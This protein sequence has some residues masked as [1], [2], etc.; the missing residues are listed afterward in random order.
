VGAWEVPDLLG[1]VSAGPVV[2]LPSGEIISIGRRP[3][4]AADGGLGFNWVSFNGREAG[5]LRHVVI[6]DGSKPKQLQT[7]K[8]D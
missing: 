3:F 4:R 2:R 7:R 8:A 1:D 5:K 6:E